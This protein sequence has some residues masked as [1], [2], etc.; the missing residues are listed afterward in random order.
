MELVYLWVEKHKNI[1]RQGFNFSPKFKC[2]FKPSYDDKGHSDNN[3]TLL[4]KKNKEN[5]N[6][7]S[8][9]INITAIVGGNGTGKS[10]LLEI[11]SNKYSLVDYK[12]LFF[13][14]FDS[15]FYR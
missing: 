15:L 3:C 10:G 4:I 6:I 1:K 9:N 5:T 2:T 13:I 12:S 7:F 8:R 14:F 11:L